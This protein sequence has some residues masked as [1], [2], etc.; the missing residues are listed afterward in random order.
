MVGAEN[1]IFLIVDRGPAYVAKKT[2]AFV[3]PQICRLNVCILMY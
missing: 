2:K 3:I 1:K